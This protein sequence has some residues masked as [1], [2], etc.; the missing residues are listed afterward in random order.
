MADLADWR[1]E[2]EALCFRGGSQSWQSALG[3]GESAKWLKKIQVAPPSLAS[4]LGISKAQRAAVCGPVEADPALVEALIDARCDEVSQ[5][6]VLLALVLS[7]EL[8]AQ[9]LAMHAQMPCRALWLVY[10]KGPKSALGDGRIRQRLR[11][12]GYR[13]SKSCAVSERLTATRY[14]K[15]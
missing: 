15:P 9:A 4:K 12:L 14:L 6:S 3:S 2:A 11:D 1:L 5:A 10:E 7:D 8:L 13:D